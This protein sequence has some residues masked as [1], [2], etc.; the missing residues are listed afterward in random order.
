MLNQL[1]ESVNTIS[2]VFSSL[3]EYPNFEV[4]RSFDNTYVRLQFIQLHSDLQ[5]SS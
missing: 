4:H 5:D 3:C 2:N 1:K